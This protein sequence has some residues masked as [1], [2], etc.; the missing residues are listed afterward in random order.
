V[1]TFVDKEE[2]EINFSRFCVDVFYGRLLEISA[3]HATF[4]ITNPI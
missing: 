3:V 1:R 2:K 4:Q